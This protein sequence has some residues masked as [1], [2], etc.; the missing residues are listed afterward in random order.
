MDGKLVDPKNYT[1]EEGSTIIKFK[2]DYVKSLDVKAHTLKV[3]VA[4]GAAE[5][6]FTLLS[7]TENPNTGDSIYMYIA[8][9]GISFIILL[10]SGIYLKKEIFN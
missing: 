1:S 2:S 9:F 6:S 3:E 5:T 4:D 10:G 7:S 8:G